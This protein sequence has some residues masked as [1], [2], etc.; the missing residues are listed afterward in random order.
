M[1]EPERRIVV[2][3]ANVLINLMHVARL[4]LCARLPS[5]QFV[6]PDHV[7]EEI[8]EP[9]QRKALDDAI[10]KGVFNVA[11][12]TDLDS[13]A[14]FD[15][16]TRRVDPGEAACLT[17][18][19]ERGWIVASDEKKRFRREAEIRIGKDRLIGTKDLY[20]MAIGAGLITVEEADSDKAA[21]GQRRFKMDF[22]SFRD[23]LP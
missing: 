20:L 8:T 9:D 5:Y 1:K 18:A 10:T 6:V 4:D 15:E 13:I 16:L 19:V 14:L 3:D 21:L 23:L 2:T 7:L 22:A 11:S 17:L 12:I